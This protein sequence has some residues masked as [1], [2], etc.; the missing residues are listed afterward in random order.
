MNSKKFW[1][2]SIGIT[3]AII[4]SCGLSFADENVLVARAELAT[5]VRPD[6][7]IG[8]PLSAPD[9]VV[10]RETPEQP[11]VAKFFI[12]VHEAV[13]RMKKSGVV[14]PNQQ[15]PYVPPSQM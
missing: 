1:K 14:K 10:K 5:E 4:F 11:I 2:F 12:R 6:L 9:V 15:G 13:N 3:L 7:G 8:T